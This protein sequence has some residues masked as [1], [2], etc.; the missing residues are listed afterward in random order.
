VK[1]FQGFFNVLFGNIVILIL[2]AALGILL[3]MYQ[4]LSSTVENMSKIMIQDRLDLTIQELSNIFDPVNQEL[5]TISLQGKKGLFPDLRDATTLNKTFIPLLKNSPSVSSL[6]L[7]NEEGDEYMLLKLD[8]LWETR[9]TKQGSKRQLPVL[10]LW[11]ENP[12]GNDQLV[13]ERTYDHEYDPRIRP[14]YDLALNS[15]ENKFNWTLPYTFFTSNQ[16]GI[17]ASKMWIDPVNGTKYAIGIDI[18]IADLSD[19]STGIDITKNGKVFI[20]SQNYDVIGLPKDPK[21]LTKKSRTQYTLTKLPELGIPVINSAVDKFQNRTDSTRYQSFN[22]EDE[23]WWAGF[24]EYELSEGNKLI[25]GVVVPETDFSLEIQDTRHLLIGGF[26]LITLFFLIILYS[27]FQMKRA[28]KIIAIEKDKNEKLLLNTLPIKVVNDLKENGKSD[29]QKFRDVTVCF[30][31]IVGFTQASSKLDPKE[32]IEELNDIYTAYDE[33]MVKY[34]CER[35]KTIGDAYL[36]VCGMPQKNPAHAEM[37]LK[38][39]LEIINFTKK[40]SSYSNMNWQIRIGL[41]S[42]NVVGGIVGVKKYIYDV[43]GDTINTAS[44]MESNSSPMKVNISEQT[45]QLV[46]DSEFVQTMNLTFEK[47]NPINVKGKGS[48]EMYF[49]TT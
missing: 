13:S 27:F 28:N 41:H 36:A 40:R 24:E 1:T 39:S 17:T 12:T 5:N 35:I 20:L 29:P 49:V 14:W 19:F 23:N 16:P 37:M 11:K 8:S 10:S 7:A 32:L 38:A 34:D 42:G 25:I 47:R 46:K 43:F 6:L 9:I 33:I 45:F 2:L 21:F 44:R 30:S 15:D 3:V 31:D 18:L 48:M 26:I 22:F 4:N